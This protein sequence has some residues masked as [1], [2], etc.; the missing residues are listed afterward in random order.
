MKNKLESRP[1]LRAP[2]NARRKFM[3]AAAAT[4]IAGIFPASLGSLTAQRTDMKAAQLVLPM[5]TKDVT[6]FKIQVPQEALDDLKVRLASTRWPDR[7]TVRDWS[8]GVPLQKAQA[9]IA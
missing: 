8:Q 9:L 1:G 4:G 3:R 2:I 7:E 6:P 5:A